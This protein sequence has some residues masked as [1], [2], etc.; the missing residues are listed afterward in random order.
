MLSWLLFFIVL[1]CVY[2]YMEYK[3]QDFKSLVVP[4]RKDY[5]QLLDER[6]IKGFFSVQDRQVAIHFAGKRGL[7]AEEIAELNARVAR[8]FCVSLESKDKIT[9]TDLISLINLWCMIDLPDG[10]VVKR[11]AEA[12]KK[13]LIR[14]IGQDDELSEIVKLKLQEKP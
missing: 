11:S 6:L 2:K 14:I 12:V 5:R 9:K 8:D 13:M 1:C 3:G 7:P 4:A 10:V